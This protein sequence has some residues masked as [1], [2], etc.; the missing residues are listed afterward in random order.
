MGAPKCAPFAAKLLASSDR[1]ERF[2]AVMLFEGASAK[3]S[4]PLLTPLLADAD[5]TLRA[6]AARILVQ[7]GD[8]KRLDWLVVESA[9]ARGEVRLV[10]EGELEKLRLSDEQRRAILEKAGLR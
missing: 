10:Y 3:V 7:G 1:N 4:S 8:L 5:D 6:R 2:Q 9:R